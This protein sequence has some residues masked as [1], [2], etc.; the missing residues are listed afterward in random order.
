MSTIQERWEYEGAP[1]ILTPALFMKTCDSYSVVK[2]CS[3]EESIEGA[4]NGLVSGY[5]D[6]EIG[7]W[8]LPDRWLFDN[9]T[10]EMLL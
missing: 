7:R 4:K 6:E 8:V 1:A 9:G 10:R 5:I 3:Y 2:T